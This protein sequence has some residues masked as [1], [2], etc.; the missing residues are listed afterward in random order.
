VLLRPKSLKDFKI[1][2][3]KIKSR[4]IRFKPLRKKINGGQINLK[5]L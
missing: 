2:K 4:K 5:K 1:E 3:D